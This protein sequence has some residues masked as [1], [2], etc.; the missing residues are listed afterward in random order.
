M[1]DNNDRSFKV[2]FNSSII[3][4]KRIVW[5][6]NSDIEKIASKLSDYEDYQKAFDKY[7]DVNEASFEYDA[8]IDK[9]TS[10]E[11]KNV[12]QTAVEELNELDFKDVYMARVKGSSTNIR[13]YFSKNGF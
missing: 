8:V 6:S 4:N 1:K 2:Q 13:A 11:I 9:L 3:K 5:L 12:Y 7:P 10:S